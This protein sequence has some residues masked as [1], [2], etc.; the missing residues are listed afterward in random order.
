MSVLVS[1]GRTWISSQYCSTK[2]IKIIKKRK[3]ERKEKK[4][5]L[6]EQKIKQIVYITLVR[7]AAHMLSSS[8]ERSV[9]HAPILCVVKMENVYS[10]T[11]VLL[12]STVFVFICAHS[13]NND[14]AQN[15]SFQLA[16]FNVAQR[17]RQGPGRRSR[18]RETEGITTPSEGSS[19]LHFQTTI[20][21][22]S[23][24]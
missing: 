12:L 4:H 18:T 13:D 19:T 5:Q 9:R 8:T 16:P 11:L 22:I 23:H 15:P 6:M 10:I 7:S 3:K 14:R 24:S 2:K 1:Q 17:G 21:K 20:N